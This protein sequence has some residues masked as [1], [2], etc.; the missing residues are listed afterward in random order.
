MKK[1]TFLKLSTALLSAPLLST[2]SACEKRERLKNWAENFTYGTDDVIN[3]KTVAKLQE[4]IVKRSKLRILGTRHCFNTIADS[5]DCLISTKNLFNILSIDYKASV[6]TVQG[7]IKYGELA[8]YLEKKGYALHNLASL[9]HI[10]VAG[11]CATATH[12]SGVTNGNL[13][14]AVVAMEIVNAKGEI[15]VLSKEKD[16]EKFEGAVV[17]LGLLGPVTKVTLKMEKTFAIKQ[18]VYQNM[19]MDSL[20]ANFDKIMA[21]GY[22]VSLFTDWQNKNINE[23]WI[24]SKYKSALGE[25]VLTDFEAKPEFYGGKLATKNLHPIAAL[26]AENC[27]EQMGLPGA[28]HDR[29]PHFKMGFTPS[30]GKELQSE[31]FVDKKNAVAAIMAIEK[32]HAKIGPLLMI[33][34]I[35][36]IAADN[37]WLSTAYK[38]DSVAIHFTWKQET[39]AV[40]ALLPEIEAALEPFDYRPHWGKLFTLDPKK[41]QSR[42]DKMTNFKELIKEFDPEGKFRNEFID[43]NLF[44]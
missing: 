27:T 9:P 37:L 28:W 12:G 30:S 33:T 26:G 2:M 24:K 8:P 41:L 15:V 19:P 43:K 44:G 13:S 11:A 5:K 31:F 32:L 16:G 25:K 35:R 18:D 1:R 3:P 7:G 29:L 17:A 22:S 42:Y 4:N 23:V 10:S 20:K 6:V 34:E 39:E 40:M 38:R 14:T 21:A 36:S